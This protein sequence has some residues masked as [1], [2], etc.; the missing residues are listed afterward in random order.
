M[1]L[2]I[3]VCLLPE[4]FLYL[5]PVR[6]CYGLFIFVF[7]VLSGRLLF[8]MTYYMSEWNVSLCL[9]ACLLECHAIFYVL[10]VGITAD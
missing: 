1:C 3:Y 9:H 5:E 4:F 8:E 2:G 6:L 10:I 7:C